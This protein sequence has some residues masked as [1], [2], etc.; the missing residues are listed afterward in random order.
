MPKKPYENVSKISS[1]K[2]FDNLVTGD[3]IW[4]YY[5]E[6]KWRCSNRIWATKNAPHPIAK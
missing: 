6:P 4:V 2:A 3:E 5:F 1:K